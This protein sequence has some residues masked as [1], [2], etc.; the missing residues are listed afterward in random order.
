MAT[1]DTRKLSG[2][3]LAAR[4]AALGISL[5]EFRDA[6]GALDEL[7]L[8]RRVSMVERYSSDFHFAKLFAACVAAFGVCG[9][10]TWLAVHFLW[11]PY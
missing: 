6:E 7:G 11:H 4:A 10:A 1:A 3:A 9:L 8:R 5:E 2:E